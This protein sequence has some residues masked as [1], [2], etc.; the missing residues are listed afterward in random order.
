MYAYHSLVASV[1]VA[2]ESAESSMN[3]SPFVALAATS[4]VSFHVLYVHACVHYAGHCNAKAV[5]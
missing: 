5:A 4:M 3:T 1:P 2:Y